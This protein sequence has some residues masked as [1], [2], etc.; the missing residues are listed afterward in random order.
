MSVNLEASVERLL[1]DI[2]EETAAVVAVR[3]ELTQRL[4]D[5]RA[6]LVRLARLERALN[7]TSAPGKT[8]KANGNGHKASKRVSQETV[9]TYL[10]PI[11]GRF[12]DREWT[13]RDAQTVWPGTSNR[14][15]SAVFAVG[16]EMQ[17][18]RLVRWDR[19]E[20]VRGQGHHVYKF[21]MPNEGVT[22]GSN[23]A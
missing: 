3:D 12:G 20:G 2:R 9:R 17:L 18:M 6:E 5:N 8:A 11:R 1:A 23:G 15:L 19:P 22:N 16:R 21:D 4:E 7:P 10:D 13:L 14:T